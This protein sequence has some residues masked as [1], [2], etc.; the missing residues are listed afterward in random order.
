M[1]EEKNKTTQ[2]KKPQKTGTDLLEKNKSNRTDYCTMSSLRAKI[3]YNFS[4]FK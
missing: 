4:V 3:L 2:N 1:Q